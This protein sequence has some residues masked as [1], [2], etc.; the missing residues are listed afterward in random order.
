MSSDLV[1]PAVGFE[2]FDSPSIAGLDDLLPPAL[3]TEADKVTPDR[4]LRH[5]SRTT[6]TAHTTL[7]SPR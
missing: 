5:P 7:S 6:P 4:R 2:P 1:W 3:V